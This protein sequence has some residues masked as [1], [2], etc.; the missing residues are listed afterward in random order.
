MRDAKGR[1]IK[2]HKINLGK[3]NVLGLHWKLPLT[4]SIRKSLSMMGK[5]SNSKGKKW[6]NEARKK[7]S[8]M[9][10]GKNGHNWRGGIKPINKKI[11]AGIEFRLWREAVFARDNWTCQKYGTRGVD[12]VPHHIKNFSQYPELRFSIDNG[13]TLSKKA[14]VE[15]HKKYGWSNN[16]TEQLTEFLKD[17]SLWGTV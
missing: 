1:F 7:F 9:F 16:E 10:I 6:T 15:F 17:R 8:L 11:R 3:K 12:L 5:P 13:I 14:H 4:D 2:G